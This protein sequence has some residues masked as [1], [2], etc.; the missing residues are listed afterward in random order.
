MRWRSS[1]S[2]RPIFRPSRRW[3]GSF[4]AALFIVAFAV[5]GA[6]L[7]ATLQDIASE[8]PSGAGRSSGGDG[9]HVDAPPTTHAPHER[10]PAAPD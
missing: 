8:P 3:R 6:G 7:V 5:V 9:T 2:K 10:A 1:R 4:G